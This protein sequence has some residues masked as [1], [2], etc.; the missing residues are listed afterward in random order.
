MSKGAGTAS[1]M[2]DSL[3]FHGANDL[4]VERSQPLEFAGKLLPA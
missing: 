1:A 4:R 2:H 3:P